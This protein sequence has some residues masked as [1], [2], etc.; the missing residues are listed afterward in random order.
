VIVRLVLAILAI[1]ALFVVVGLFRIAREAL[2][3]R[4]QTGR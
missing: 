4:R 1:L 2:S 3:R